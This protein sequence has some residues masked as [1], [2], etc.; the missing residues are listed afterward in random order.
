MRSVCMIMSRR[1][2]ETTLFM[3]VSVDGKISTGDSDLLD[4]DRD[5]PRIKGIREGYPQYDVLLSKTDRY[6]LNTGKVMAKIGVNT[7]KE[8]PEKIEFCFIIIDRKPHLNENGI[9]YLTK[10]AKMLY[11]V[12]NNHHHPA[13]NL[14][15]IEN[16][17]IIYYPE[18]IDLE[19]LLIRFRKDYGVERITIYPGGTLNSVFL[20][21]RLIDHLS[22]VI[23]P[24][25]IGGKNTPTLIDGRSP[26]T[27]EDLIH[28]KALKLNKCEVLKNSY[29]H[30]HYDVI[31]N[32]EIVQATQ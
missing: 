17:E 19:N 14:K 2:V 13:F 4:M 32:T 1:R 6:C 25:L 18:K 16:L 9:R 11:I 31:N 10:W 20:K 7:R 8:E 27:E 26:H 15:D 30:L 12:T 24:A 29:L 3:I 28:V 5:F 23:A 22:I 21:K